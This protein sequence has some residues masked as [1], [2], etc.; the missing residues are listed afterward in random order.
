MAVHWKSRKGELKTTREQHLGRVFFLSSFF[1][2]VS[3][4]ALQ[5]RSSWFSITLPKVNGLFSPRSAAELTLSNPWAR[6]KKKKNRRAAT[7]ESDEHAHRDLFFSIF[8][9]G[10]IQKKEKKTA[11]RELME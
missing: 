3:F 8:S 11:K 6:K 1:P 9:R 4:L 10:G 5:P 2:F 7:N